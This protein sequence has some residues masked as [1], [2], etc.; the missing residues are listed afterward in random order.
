[1]ASVKCLD[2][3]T[4]ILTISHLQ[5][6]SSTECHKLIFCSLL[7]TQHQ[8]SIFLAMKVLAQEQ[9]SHIVH[10]YSV[11]FLKLHSRYELYTSIIHPLYHGV[12]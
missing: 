10:S 11:H 12:Q 4:L 8:N 5:Y 6:I 7:L 9:L 3:Y 1:M 2:I